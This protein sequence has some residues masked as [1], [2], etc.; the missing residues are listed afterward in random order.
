MSDSHPPASVPPVTQLGFRA[1]LRQAL[2]GGELDYT[3]L[4]LRRA[5]FLLAVPMVLEMAMESLFAVAD[6][7][8]VSRLG[9]DAVATVGLTESLL[10][11]VYAVAVG[12]SVAAT[13]VVS[14]R[15]G[16]GDPE[17]A[18]LAA[19]QVLLLTC[20]LS[21]VIGVIGAWSGP[22]LL[23]LMGAS[24]AVLEQGSLYISVT[25]GGSITVIL[26]FALN[27][28]FRGAGDAV[29]AMHSLWLANLANI[30]LDPLFIFGLGP[31]PELGVLGAGVATILGRGIGV[32][33][34]L[35]LLLRRRGR[36][37][38]RLSHLR[39]HA[40]VQ[41]SLIDISSTGTLQST[42]ET[43]SWLGLVRILSTFGSVA[44]AGYTIAM[45]VAVFALLPSWGLSNAAA[46]L[47]GQNLGAGKPERAERAVWVVGAYNFAFLGAVGLVFT[48][49]PQPILRFFTE[50]PDE[51]SFATN[52]LRIVA[53]GF[54]FYAYGMVL[55]QAFNGAG[56]TRTPT[57]LNLLC[58][59][60]FKI[61]AAYVLALPLGLGPNGVFIAITC[62]YSVLAM[63]ALWLFRRGTWKTKRI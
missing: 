5:A 7:F 26:L 51:L 22:S 53:L 39:P 60:F 25:L 52:C 2:T 13:A 58:F 23:R 63:L 10:A 1:L 57:V 48:L 38:V 41:K 37:Q 27:A 16:E 31:F 61:P 3:A 28:V 54:L 20:V 46:T 59:W 14:R 30:V 9:A 15:I 43:A 44:L 18:S 55:V 42:L 62:A 50:Q 11:M 8:F 6:I 12:L 17:A 21:I 29:T 47:V 35:S 33:Y 24:P 4:P 19:G 34:Q 40:Q 49:T 32:A 56:D 45:R 36:L